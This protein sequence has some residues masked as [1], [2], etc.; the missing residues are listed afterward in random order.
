[1]IGLD[2]IIVNNLLTTANG[3][4]KIHIDYATLLN[5]STNTIQIFSLETT[6]AT[7]NGIFRRY[8]E[9]VFFIQNNLIQFS[10]SCYSLTNFR[11]NSDRVRLEKNGI[12]SNA[13]IVNNNLIEIEGENTED[14]IYYLPDTPTN[15]PT[16]LNNFSLYEISSD[17]QNVHNSDVMRKFKNIYYKMLEII[18]NNS[19]DELKY[20]WFN[21]EIAREI[22]LKHN[23][24]RD[25]EFKEKLLRVLDH[26]KKHNGY[27]SNINA[28]EI[29]VFRNIILYLSEIVLDKSSLVNNLRLLADNLVD[30]IENDIIVCLTGR[31]NRM[32]N[33]IEP[34]VST[35][36]DK[37]HIYKN[38]SDAREDMLKLSTKLFQSGKKIENIKNELIQEFYYL[39]TA[40]I[41]LE[42]ESWNLEDL[43]D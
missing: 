1:M 19:T 39:D 16:V 2:E 15:R 33:S 27:L 31:V 37:S 7:I 43:F 14:Y 17:S 20:K 12:I 18:D 21:Y 34:V 38:I 11:I 32:I 26:S 9:Y 30:S 35:M 42:I 8:S 24:E 22:L 3:D 25:V 36:T 13:I 28:S 29:Q 40:E 10:G 23:K 41:L 4:F 5:I 6:G